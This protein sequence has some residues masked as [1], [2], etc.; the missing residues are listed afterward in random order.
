MAITRQLIQITDLHLCAAADATLHGW[1]VDAAWRRVLAAALERYPDAD[2]LA[3]TGDLVDDESAAGYQRLNAQL[4]SLGR[5][6]IA[7]AGNHDDPAAMRRHLT[8]AD[9]HG[10][11]RLGGWQLHGLGSHVRGSDAARLGADQIARLEARLSADPAPAL[12]FV[13]HPPVAIGAAWIDDIG[14]ADGGALCAMLR[15]FDHVQAVV[16]GHAHQAVETRIGSIPCW[17]T[18]ATMR[19]FL[20]GSDTF[21]LDRE[22]FPGYRLIELDPRGHAVSRVHR[23]DTE[24]CG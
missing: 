22:R 21:A 1:P 17:V 4:E 20:P 11:S 16:C 9:V 13:H 2:A 7:I 19:Q 6:V 10:I 15:R 23:V 3:L 14:L 8:C 5:P 12:V 24:A 18:P